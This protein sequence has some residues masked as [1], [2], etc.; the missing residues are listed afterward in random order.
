MLHSSS[1]GTDRCLDAAPAASN[2]PRLSRWKAA[3]ALAVLQLMLGA[4]AHAGSDPQP[5]NFDPLTGYRIANYRAP[6]P[7]SVP[8]GT[9]ISLEELE[10]M[11]REGKP[12]LL[13]VNA[14]EGAGPNP[15]SGVWQLSRQ[16]VNKAGT[17]WLPDVGRGV[18]TPEFETYFKDNLARLTGGDMTRAIIIYCQAD[19]WMSWNAVKRAASYGYTALYWYP[20]GTDGM[21]DWDVS[22]VES[23]PVPMSISPGRRER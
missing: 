21:R 3:S 15:V 18:L 13:D 22:L 23:T 20:D 1:P 12:V 17:V 14:A 16:R 5:A 9:V 19:C 8:G 10:N 2:L 11:V 4:V 7:S 6:T